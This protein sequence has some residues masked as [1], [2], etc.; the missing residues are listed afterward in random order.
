MIR[1][2]SYLV[3]NTEESKENIYIYLRDG[4][5]ALES[6]AIVHVLHIFFCTSGHKMLNLTESQPNDG[7]MVFVVKL[8]QK[9]VHHG[10]CSKAAV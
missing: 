5:F 4:V 7:Y 10:K 2:G 9:S 6:G 1:I 8:A 3:F